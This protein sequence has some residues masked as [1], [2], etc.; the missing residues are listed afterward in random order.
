[1]YNVELRDFVKSTFN[2]RFD[3]PRHMTLIVKVCT[4][5][6]HTRAAVSDDFGHKYVPCKGSRFIIMLNS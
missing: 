5:P 1:M 6:L 4:L 3:G 2:S